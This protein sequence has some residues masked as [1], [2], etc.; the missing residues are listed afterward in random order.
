[1]PPLTEPEITHKIGVV[2]KG[3]DPQPP[4]VAAFLVAVKK[5]I[6]S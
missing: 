6:H 1:M 2:L 4:I 3:Q 5:S